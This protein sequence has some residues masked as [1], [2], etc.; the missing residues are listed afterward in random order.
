[1]N[2][3]IVAAT[4]KGGPEVTV[5]KLRK[6]LEKE[7]FNVHL[8]N[9]YKIRLSS[10]IY[11]FIPPIVRTTLSDILSVKNLLSEEYDIALYASGI[12][13]ISIFGLHSAGIAT[14]YYVQGYFYHE[15]LGWL[16]KGGFRTK[17]GAYKNILLYDLQNTLKQVDLYIL[18]CKS[19]GVFSRINDNY[20]VLPLWVFYDEISTFAEIKE[21]YYYS[22][23]FKRPL[24]VTYTSRVYSPKI[25][26]TNCIIRLLKIIKRTVHDFSAIIID[27]LGIPRR[28]DNI[29]VMNSISHESFL[30]LL[31]K[32]SLFID[33]VIDEELRHSTLEAMILGVPVAKIVHPAYKLMLD[34][35]EGDLLLSYSVQDAVSKISEY[36]SQ[37]EYY[38][39]AYSKSCENFVIRKREWNAV[40]NPFIAALKRIV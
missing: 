35:N 33:T 38:Y 20:V 23:D 5:N 12:P 21:T 10:N 4:S 25:I 11:N 31:A 3:L 36:L 15:M 30:K 24:I 2:I 19:S 22:K 32:A 14:A 17:I 27:P 7:G 9:P 37:A 39:N 34:Y 1:M 8:F 18:T 26:P 6:G 29:I 40:K 28:F 13:H 16:I